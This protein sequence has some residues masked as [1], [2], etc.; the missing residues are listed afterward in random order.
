MKETQTILIVAGGTGG[1]ISPG[2]ALAEE[3]L[4]QKLNVVFLSIPRN[5]NYAGFRNQPFTIEFYTAPGLRFKVGAIVRFIPDFIRS[6]V[7]ALKLFRK[8]NPS[9]IIALGG[10]PSLPAAIA[11][12]ANRRPLFLCE[13][14]AVV[15]RVNRWL[16]RFAVATFST[17]GISDQQAGSSEKERIRIT[18]N[19]VR[20]SLKERAK[21]YV[22]KR[23]SFRKKP[24]ILILGGSQGALQLNEMLLRLW[25]E[26]PGLIDK[27]NWIL[28]A[29]ADHVDDLR[30]RI[31]I[32]LSAKMRTNI[33]LFG[34]DPDIYRYFERADFC[35]SRAGAGNI[36][37]ALLFR[38]P[39]ILVPYP[40]ASD[41]H[42]KENA[43]IIKEAGAAILIDRNDT[44][45]S[46]LLSAVESL[47]QKEKYIQMSDASAKLSKIDAGTDIIS[48]TMAAI[49]AAKA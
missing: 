32:A 39:M 24:T 34:F 19:P 2:V 1:H 30:H 20:Q 47:M 41:H 3:A 14:N 13:Q 15:G 21:K 17:F 40:F 35:I 43:M 12:I 37:E 31:E 8:Y 7:T 6:V 42:Q 38:L 27:A 25:F 4:L 46:E 11:A 33:E 45:P 22:S 23:R 26:N 9:A 10:Y 49:S 28:Q 29:G 16:G 36:T 48:Y 44:E 18:G 5:Q